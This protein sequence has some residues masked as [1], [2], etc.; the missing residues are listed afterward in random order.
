MNTFLDN[1]NYDNLSKRSFVFAR[2]YACDNS[3]GVESIDIVL[4]DKLLEPRPACGLTRK[5]TVIF[6]SV[7][8]N[9]VE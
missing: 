4:F 7:T 6:N 2:I 9:R 1:D 5:L 3:L 8:Y